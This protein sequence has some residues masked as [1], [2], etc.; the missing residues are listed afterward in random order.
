MENLNFSYNWNNKLACPCFTTLRL[1][2]DNKYFPGARFSISLHKKLL[3]HEVEVIDVKHLYLLQ[4]NEF[5]ARL[6]TGYSKTECVK[7]IKTMYKNSAINW[8]TKQLSIILF[9]IPSK[10]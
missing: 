2:N 7:L 5:I 4:I 8:S 10:K 3:I 9:S 6:D 1:R